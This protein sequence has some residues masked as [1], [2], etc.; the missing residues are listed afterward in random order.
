MSLP[1]Q[2]PVTCPKCGHTQE[3]TS[4]QSLNVTADPEKKAQL[5]AGDLTRFTCAQCRT[6][7]DVMYPMLYHDMQQR[8][9]IWFWT[10]EGD[11]DTNALSIGDM[12][13]QYRLRIVGSRNELVEKIHIFDAGL[14]DEVIEIVKLL[15]QAQ[16]EKSGRTLGE[17]YF[18]RKFHGA[19]GGAIEFL[20][21]L[22]DGGHE[23]FEVPSAAYDSVSKRYTSRLA[24]KPSGRERWRRIGLDYAVAT[25]TAADENDRDQRTRQG[26]EED[27]S[28]FLTKDSAVGYLPDLIHAGHIITTAG[29]RSAAR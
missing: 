8:V 12:L 6:S 7:A 2:T 1:N 29:P 9:M 21:L 24:A 26:A 10:E 25:L 3:F 19:D 23:S 20:R 18:G 11:P 15:V 14:D 22:E 4:W 16:E 17:L 27:T 5:L 13:D 28:R